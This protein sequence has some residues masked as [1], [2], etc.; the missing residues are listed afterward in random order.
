M[1]DATIFTEP[2]LALE[3]AEYRAKSEKT[4]MSI[5]SHED[6]YTVMPLEKAKR[7]IEVVRAPEG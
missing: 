2:N 1:T 4:D 5:C 3:E 7:V 6:G